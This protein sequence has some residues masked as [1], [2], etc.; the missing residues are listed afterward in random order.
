[1]N[2]LEGKGDSMKRLC[3]VLLLCLCCFWFAGSA[4]AATMSQP[5]KLTGKLVYHTYSSYDAEDSKYMSM[6]LKVV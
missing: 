2:E 3:Q 5:P 6:I 1:M 4:K